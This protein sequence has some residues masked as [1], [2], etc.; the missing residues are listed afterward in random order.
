MTLRLNRP[1]DRTCRAFMFEKSETSGVMRDN[2]DCGL[3]AKRRFAR[4]DAISV[5]G[6]V[7]RRRARWMLLKSFGTR[8]LHV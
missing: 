8:G 2:L 5:T 4:H 1:C 6:V 7:C 3:G